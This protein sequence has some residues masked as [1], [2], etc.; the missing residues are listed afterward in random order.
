MVFGCQGV[1]EIV[2]DPIQLLIEKPQY[3]LDGMIYPWP[4]QAKA[5]SPS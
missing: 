1:P 2:F 4:A 3:S 5:I